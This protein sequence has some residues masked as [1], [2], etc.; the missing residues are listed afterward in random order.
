MKFLIKKLQ[1]NDIWTKKFCNKKSALFR[2][3]RR[4]KIW[5]VDFEKL[6]R[7][8]ERL[9]VFENAAV[10][11]KLINKNYDDFLIDHFDF[12]KIFELL[13]RKYYWIDC[14]K[15]TNEYVKICDICQR[16]KAF[17]HKSYDKLSFL[18]ISKNFWKKIIWNFIT[19]L[20]SNKRKKI[21]YDFIFVI[22]NRC[23]KMIKYISI[24][25]KCDSAKLT[26]IFF[27]KIVFNFDMFINIMSDRNSIF[28][29]VFWSVLCYYSKIKRR[30][31]TAFHS[32]TN[33][34]IERQNQVFEQYLR[35]FVD[36]K[37]I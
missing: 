12:D 7:H 22:M 33:D 9:Y 15:Q 4:S 6:V 13:Q 31:S 14:D 19:E 35:T 25:V 26:K 10:R 29:S 37:Q 18:S 20:S 24:I 32:Q 28:T 27:E 8:N 16:I 17:R 30:L 36:A 11:K 21:V 5:T 2:R 3:R 23:I 1:A 34:L